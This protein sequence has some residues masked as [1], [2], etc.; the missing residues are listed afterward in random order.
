MHNVR[1]GIQSLA[2]LAAASVI[3][4]PSPKVVIPINLD[5][6]LVRRSAWLLTN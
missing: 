5:T 4:P 3:T 1:R 6:S 2:P